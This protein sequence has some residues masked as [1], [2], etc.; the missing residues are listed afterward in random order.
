MNCCC[1]C[2]LVVQ[3]VYDP[4]FYSGSNTKKNT[5]LIYI[6]CAPQ[7]DIKFK[8]E[9]LVIIRTLAI[10][11]KKHCNVKRGNIKTRSYN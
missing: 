6:F 7:S 11:V 4:T 9:C 1:C 3:G 5:Y 2:F 10:N 8:T